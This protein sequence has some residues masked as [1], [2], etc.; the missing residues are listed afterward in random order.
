[1]TCLFTVFCP[2][3]RC[4]SYLYENEEWIDQLPI[5]EAKLCDKLINKS[6]D[7][8]EALAALVEP[9]KAETYSLTDFWGSVVV[10]AIVHEVSRKNLSKNC[11]LLYLLL[12]ILFLKLQEKQNKTW[13]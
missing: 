4:M 11:K 2:L 12:C 6:W 13:R 10:Y 1:M 8:K 7:Y 3:P 9:S 5:L